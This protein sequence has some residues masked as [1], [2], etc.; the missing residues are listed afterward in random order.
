MVRTNAARRI[1]RM[2]DQ[3]S[4]RNRS[5]MHCIRET[6]C[7][8]YLAF[9]THKA[10]AMHG[11]IARPEPA[12]VDRFRLLNISPESFIDWLACCHLRSTVDRTETALPLPH[13]LMRG[14]KDFSAMFTGLL[15]SLR[16]FGIDRLDVAHHTSARTESACLAHADVNKGRGTGRTYFG[17]GHGSFLLGYCG[18]VSDGATNH[19]HDRVYQ[20]KSL[21][22]IENINLSYIT[23]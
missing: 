13:F 5:I 23:H 14:L 6:M 17:L 22:S 15:N 8:P 7:R 11:D 12:I 16:V 3:K 1:T 21:A 19:L 4:I 20:K 10:I 2:T 9:Y 18:V